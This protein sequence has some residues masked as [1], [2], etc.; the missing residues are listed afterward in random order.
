MVVQGA[1]VVDFPLK[2]PKG[3]IRALRSTTLSLGPFRVEKRILEV[4]GKLLVEL[5]LRSD[6]SLPDLTLTDPLPQGGEKAFHFPA[7]Q[8]EEVLTYEL[9][10]A[11]LTDPEVRWRYP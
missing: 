2:P 1:T 10:E 6:E 8:G 5:R 4:N 7:F 11:F 9:N 3:L